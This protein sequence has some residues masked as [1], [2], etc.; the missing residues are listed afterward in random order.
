ME[1]N[2]SAALE[3]QRSAHPL[4]EIRG[5]CVT[6]RRH[7]HMIQAVAGLTFRLGAGRTL[8]IIGESG[9]GKTV[10]CRAL[11]G[12]L[13]ASATVTGSARLAGTDLIALK[14]PEMRRHRGSAISMV[15]QDPARSLNP[16]MRVGYQITEVVRHHEPVDGQTARRRALELLDLL[17]VPDAA[18]RFLAYPHELSGGTRQRVLIAI[19][20]AG[21]PKL[22]IADEAT[23]SLD[24]ITQAGILALLKDLQRQLNMAL[25]L[26]S[27][28]LSLASRV[29]DEILVMYAG[30]AVEHAATRSLFGHPRMP[31]TRALID[32]IPRFDLP[33]HSPFPVVPGH[34]PDLSALPAGCAFAPRCGR[35]SARCKD[36]QP[37]FAEQ[38]HE[39]RYACW[40]PCDDEPRS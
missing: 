1:Q 35:A 40:N 10:S 33:P 2:M 29:A 11:M 37:V 19:A 5:L 13:P 7:P 39:H 21:R 16:T 28:D 6:F 30:R 3:A 15:F 8:A 38:A 14:E 31:Y 4:L 9:S 26:V 27:H 20:L 23:R 22:L 36:T 17:R 12:L 34:P 24:A 32:A 18:R 25:I